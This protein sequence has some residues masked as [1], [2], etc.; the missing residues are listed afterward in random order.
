MT[1]E[2]SKPQTTLSGYD[3]AFFA[4]LL[5]V[6]DRHFWFRA[7]NYLITTLVERIAR[8]FPPRYRVL[9]VGCV[10]G[11]VLR[12]L[13]RVCRGATVVGM[14][15]FA[16][17]LGCARD[18]AGCP[19]VQGNAG[20]TP[21]RIGFDLV[22]IFDVLEHC[23]DDMQVL[24]DLHA[25][26]VPGGVLLL[27]VPAGKVLWS[28]F[29]E[30]SHHCR[31][32]EA[33][34]LAEKLRQAGF[35]LELVTHYMA[36]IYPLVRL[37]RRLRTQDQRSR[38]GGLDA[39]SALR[40]EFTMVPQRT[41]FLRWCCGP[42][43]LGSVLGN[44]LPFG[45]SLVAFGPTGR[46]RSPVAIAFRSFS[47]NGALA[48]TKQIW[49]LS[50]SEQI[51]AMIAFVASLVARGLALLPA[52]AVDD[53]GFM[54]ADDKSSSFGL[55]MSQGRPGAVLLREVL[56]RLD[57]LPPKSG[58]L[59]SFVL[60]LVLVWVGILVCRMWG[61]EHLPVLSGLV[62]LFICLHPYQAEV[63]TFRVAA[64]TLAAA[65]GLAFYGISTCFDSGRTQVSAVLLVTA[66][67][68]TY[69]VVL[70]Y[71]A[72]ALFFSLVFGVAHMYGL[73]EPATSDSMQSGRVL[74]SQ[75]LTLVLAAA[76]AM[77]ATWAI[78][79]LFRVPQVQRTAL[80]TIS[81]FG[82]RAPLVFSRL[83][84]MFSVDEAVLPIAT[85]WLLALTPLTALGLAAFRSP[86]GALKELCSRRSLPFVLAI[87]GGVPASLGVVIVL[88]EWWPVS[89]VCAHV[90][91]FWAGMF[92]L[93][94][95]SIPPQP[96]RLMLILSGFIVLSFIGTNEHI[97]E[98]Q[99]RVNLRD[100]AKANRIIS[101]LEA[102]PDFTPFTGVVLVGGQWG[103]YSP[104]N[105]TQGD[106][107]IS[108]LFAEWSKRPLLN[109]VSGYNLQPVP[110]ALVEKAN[111]HCLTAPKW[112]AAGSVVK[113]DT[114]AVVCMEK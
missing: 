44:R 62:V 28:Y 111:T 114:G 19:V 11:N 83:H 35:H 80:L 79:I 56:R 85:K 84:I 93:V 4:E 18:R 105:T 102:L 49:R 16:E 74:R 78:P 5:R 81:E 50:R 53:Y 91:I 96:R 71:L 2:P 23:P 106:M 38:D 73:G 101:R 94:F 89:R 45:T 6:E 110:P 31:R 46:R 29:D 9:E 95:M 109:E 63:F 104:I 40:S 24:R 112:P 47:P 72:M 54:V 39:I 70:N 27:T 3:A 33:P 25:L 97:F 7:R 43:R 34:E 8:R 60:T 92:A 51:V 20:C 1:G 87:A 82:T 41:R 76:C 59:G 90:S 65:L 98:D 113:I 88:Q 13:V 58:V 100:M 67:L 10:N 107:N 77:L 12:H 99:L 108:A 37:I 61:I 21:F 86:T 64:F 30:I 32:Y 22:G 75:L 26:L 14:D 69:Q 15:L 48:M 52:Y 57:A 42:R 17:G 66:A 103:Y 68:L 55:F 36:A